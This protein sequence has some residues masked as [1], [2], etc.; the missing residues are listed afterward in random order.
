MFKTKCYPKGSVKEKGSFLPTAL[1][2]QRKFDAI[3][4]GYFGD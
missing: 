3:G 1:I 2:V 4:G